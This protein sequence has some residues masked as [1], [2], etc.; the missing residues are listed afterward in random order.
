MANLTD[1]EV[2]E[3]FK[4]ITKIFNAFRILLGNNVT[5]EQIE[6]DT[7]DIVAFELN[8]TQV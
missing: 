3:Q 7:G 6:I 4:D 2:D 1:G 8:L 5:D